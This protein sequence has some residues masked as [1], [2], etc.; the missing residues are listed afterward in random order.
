MDPTNFRPPPSPPLF[1]GRDKELAWLERE[2]SDPEAYRRAPIAVV[3]PGG[4][5]KT[6]LVSSFFEDFFEVRKRPLE[7]AWIQC[8]TFQED[9]ARFDES[10][11]S[12]VPRARERLS[13]V[14]D[15]ADEI[16]GKDFVSV[17]GRVMNYKRV[18]SIIITKRDEA[19]LGKARMLRL[20]GLDRADAERMIGDAQLSLGGAGLIKLIDAADG[21][22]LA[23]SL[24]TKLAQS[25]NREELLRV[26]DGN[27]YG[28][29]D[30]PSVSKTELIKVV[31]PTIVSAGAAMIAA[32]KKQPDGILKL[33]SRQFEELVTELLRDMGWDVELTPATRDGGKDILA[34]L[35]TECGTFLCLVEAK[36]YRADRKI[37]V[38][39][40]RTL[41]GTL[42]DYQAN[43]AMMV[44]T[45]SFSRDARTLEK[46]HE[47]QLKL[48]DYTDVVGWIVN[49][50]RGRPS[51]H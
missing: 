16:P 23:L 22:P 14:L 25:V 6:A 44:T 20:G 31:Q 47:F 39:L 11:R 5:G 34:Y 29:E 28:A 17:L 46:K 18:G 24:L 41:Y 19:L 49:H 2:T 9:A 43:S 37:G 45:S 33:G 15:G 42:C 50:G 48:R 13:V 7:V 4:I 35:K 27:I 1:F 38:E 30:F 26:L 10:V 12:F 51:Q 3:G 40:V 21:H 32:L 8:R 36:R